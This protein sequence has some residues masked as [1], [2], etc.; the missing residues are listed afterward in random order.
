MAESW[1]DHSAELARKAMERIAS[2]VQQYQDGEINAFRVLLAADVLS[3][4]TQG[5]IDNETWNTIYAVR[6][7]M[8]KI[9]Q[10][11]RK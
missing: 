5:L 4:V 1:P 3:E 9:I 10:A 8:A 11:A 2:D 6:G 7:E